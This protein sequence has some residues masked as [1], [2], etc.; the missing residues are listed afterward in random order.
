M[1]NIKWD[2]LRKDEKIY[3]ITA[4]LSFLV[5]V[6]FG[7]LDRPRLIYPSVILPILNLIFFIYLSKRK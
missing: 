1:I 5:V 3:L 4:L 6:A 7:V 2:S